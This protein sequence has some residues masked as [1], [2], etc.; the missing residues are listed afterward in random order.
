MSAFPVS[1]TD[2]TF[3]WDRGN[4]DHIARHNITPEEAERVFAHGPIKIEEQNRNGEPRAL[5]LGETDNSRILSLVA[6][7]RNQ[8]LRVVTAWDTKRPMRI[9]YLKAKGREGEIA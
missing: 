7:M 1:F 8:D 5:Y 6:T 9:A 4:L 3:S 2:A